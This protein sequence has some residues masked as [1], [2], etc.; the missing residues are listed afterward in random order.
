MNQ[1]IEAI[2]LIKLYRLEDQCS[3]ELQDLIKIYDDDVRMCNE[4]KQIVNEIMK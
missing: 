3:K 4:A 1:M 2:K